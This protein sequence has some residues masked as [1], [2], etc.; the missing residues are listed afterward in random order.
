VFGENDSGADYGPPNEFEDDD[1]DDDDDGDE[2]DGDDDD[3]EGSD[4]ANATNKERFQFIAEW[5]W[6]CDGNAEMIFYSISIGNF[7][8][9][10]A[11]K[12]ILIGQTQD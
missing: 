3:D 12:F 7:P 8:I 4:K 11:R 5:Q 1:D 10:E 2:V 9:N 6:Q